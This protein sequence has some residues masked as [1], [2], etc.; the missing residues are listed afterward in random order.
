M[1]EMEETTGSVYTALGM[2]DAQE[3]LVKA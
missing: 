2:A 3:M 1:I